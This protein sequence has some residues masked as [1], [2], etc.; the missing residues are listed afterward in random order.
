[1]ANPFTPADAGFWSVDDDLRI[2]INSARFI[3]AG[4]EAYQLRTYAGRPCNST[5]R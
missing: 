2:V 4:P 1:M 3:E 5:R